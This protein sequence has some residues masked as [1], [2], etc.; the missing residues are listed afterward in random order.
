MFPLIYLWQVTGDRW[1]VTGDRR[2]ATGNRQQ[3]TG[4]RWQVTGD[5]P[6]YTG[7]LNNLKYFIWTSDL[8]SSSS[9]IRLFIK[10]FDHLKCYLLRQLNELDRATLL[11]IYPLCTNS[12]T[13]NCKQL[14]MY[15]NNWDKGVAPVFSPAYLVLV[16]I[17]YQPEP[18]PHTFTF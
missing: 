7:L 13:Q 18:L 2:Q 4:D 3:A 8:R 14:F 10:L 5:S 12:T 16:N 9:S 11:V 6:S 1:Q 17:Q 15:I